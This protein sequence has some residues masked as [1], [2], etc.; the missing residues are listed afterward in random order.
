MPIN[1]QNTDPATGPAARETAASAK[2]QYPA[3][4]SP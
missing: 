4:T 3:P 2:V 1:I